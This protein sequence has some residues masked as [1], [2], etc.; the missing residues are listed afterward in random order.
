M[1]K[2]SGKSYDDF[3]MGRV[4]KPLGMEDTRHDS[5]DEIVPNRAIG[6]LWYGAGGMH[7]CEFLKYQMTNH[8]D[9]GILSTALLIGPAATAL[10]LTRR[11]W[12]AML[13]A[14]GL[15]LAA[16]WIGIVLAYDSYHWPYR[17]WPV[18]FFVVTF[19]LIAYLVAGVATRRR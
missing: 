9:R 16:T 10:R 5:P 15:G 12:R 17:G 8:G 11:P 4:F 1:R 2:V 6:Y 19:V 13:A 14:A 3:L 7:N 18:S